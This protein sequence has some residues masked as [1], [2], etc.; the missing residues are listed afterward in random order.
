MR[1]D[2]INVLKN[3]EQAVDIYQL[4]DLL[5]ISTTEDTT[6]LSEELRKLEDEAI[7]YRSHKDKYMMI[8]KSHLRKGVMR[9]NKKG[10]GFVEFKYPNDIKHNFNITSF[11]SLL[12]YF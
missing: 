11:Q 3:C 4:S 6:L 12:S 9:A 1:D 5:N 10:F 7:I 8:E 2:I